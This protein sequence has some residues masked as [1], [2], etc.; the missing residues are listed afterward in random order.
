MWVSR[1]G[2]I[3]VG[4][5]VGGIAAAAVVAVAAPAAAKCGHGGVLCP[6]PVRLRVTVDGPGLL[7]PIVIRGEDAWTMVN[8]TGLNY[9]P[10]NVHDGEPTKKGPRYEAVYE[11]RSEER[12]L[13]L[14][15]DIYPYATGTTYAFTRPGQRV[16]E[17]YEE[18]DPSGNFFFPM[19]EA[20]HGWRG[21]RTLE[22]I[23]REHGFPSQIP[24][25]ARAASHPVA[26]SVGGSNPPWWFGAVVLAAAVAALFAFRRRSA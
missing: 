26:A 14:R 12:L 2:R 25:G 20:G 15:Q 17:Q 6:D 22:T 9:R 19:T 18:M 3:L 11:F 1:S 24:A 10:Y 4:G 8:V 7:E 21:S 23:L 16:V 13:F 5:I